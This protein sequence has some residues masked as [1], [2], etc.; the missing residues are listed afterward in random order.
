MPEDAAR[1]SI[2]REFMR[3][4]GLRY[5]AA[6]RKLDEPPGPPFDPG[7]LNL[8]ITLCPVCGGDTVYWVLRDDSP[9]PGEMLGY[10]RPVDPGFCRGCHASGDSHTPDLW[11]LHKDLDPG[12]CIECGQPPVTSRHLPGIG[13]QAP[14]EHQLRRQPRPG[15]RPLVPVRMPRPALVD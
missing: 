10:T 3:E 4:T 1:K 8:G 9:E 15:R 5:T 2:I 13:R 7:W 6:R 14:Q 11:R 12:R